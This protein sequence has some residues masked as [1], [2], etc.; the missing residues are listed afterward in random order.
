[1]SISLVI[2]DIYEKIFYD[3]IGINFLLT[4]I[5]DKFI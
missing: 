2:Q 3:K 4:R 1:M 5:H